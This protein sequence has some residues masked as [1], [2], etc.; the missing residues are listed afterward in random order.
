MGASRM[1]HKVFICHSSL[2]KTIADAACGALEA[3]GVSCWIAPRDVLPGI[4]YG[5]AIID[6]L[7][8][9]EIVLLIFSTHADESPQVRRE[10]ER[11]VSKGKIILPFRIENVLPSGAMEFALSNTHW[12]DAF[13]PP[14]ESHLVKLCHT[15]SRLLKTESESP[16]LQKPEAVP[17]QLP[18]IAQSANAAHQS[19]S[20]PQTPRMAPAPFQQ[21]TPS[22]VEPHAASD[23]MPP[24]KWPG[25]ASE[26]ISEASEPEP[27]SQEN[28]STADAESESDVAGF[29]A[30]KTLFEASYA[31]TPKKRNLLKVFVLALAV[32]LAAGFIIWNRVGKPAT[33]N[34]Q[35]MTSQSRFPAVDLAR[36]NNTIAMPEADQSD[37]I[38]VTI[39][40]DGNVFLGQNRIDPAQLGGLSL[41]NQAEKVVYVRADSRTRYRT[42]EDAIDAMRRTGAEQVGLM[43]QNEGDAQQDS[44][45]SAYAPPKSTGL[46]VLLPSPAAAPTKNS[47][48][49]DRT[50]VLQVLSRSGEAPAYKINETDVNDSDLLSRLQQIYANRT[51]RV[52]F[53]RGDDDLEF[54]YIADVIDIAKASGVDHIGLMTPGVMGGN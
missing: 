19:Q 41:A 7:S 3:K 1:A 18:P 46:E 8:G 25:G 5:T 13:T 39:T 47:N 31:G 40:R 34:P 22:L 45:P 32:L 51:E 23:P 10:I 14:L 37:A 29:A 16:L 11:A 48:T 24:A 30:G 6:A 20:L 12:L 53:V 52:M 33:E 38:V 28:E 15:M 49:Q 9:C 42:V 4:E 21:P 36:E 27:R 44:P 17:E 43:T 2:D 50:I 35:G 26:P 54:R